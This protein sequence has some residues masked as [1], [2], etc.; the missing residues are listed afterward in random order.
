MIRYALLCEHDHEFESWFDSSLA[1]DKLHKTGLV[2]CPHC[3]STKT[4]KALMTPQISGTRSNKKNRDGPDNGHDKAPDQNLQKLQT[5]ATELARKI[6][7]HVTENAEHVGDNF[8]DEARK[9][10]FEESEP[11]N[12]Y[13]NAT[14]EEVSDLAEDGIDFAPLPDLPE[15]KN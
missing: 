9:I 10:H 5:E 6:R 1:F 4:R 7:H 8:A 11:R 13:G 12:I 15:D 3:G 14:K 2:E